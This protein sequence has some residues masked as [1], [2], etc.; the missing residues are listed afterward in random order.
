MPPARPVSE[1]AFFGETIRLAD[2]VSE[3]ALME[4]AEAA[5]Q[6]DD[7]SLAGMAAVMRL[8]KESVL[9]EDWGKFRDLART[10]KASIEDC[11]P[12]VVA[13]FTAE[14]GRPTV[15]PSDSSDGP[16]AT[17][18]S[19]TDVSAGVA[20]RALAGR[21]DLQLMVLNAQEARSA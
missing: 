14:T 12:V 11:M 8:L 6:V 3:W 17:S 18:T 7:A 2:S 10:N 21:P 1:V 5:E 4:F 16:P 13:V 9:A 15:R 20:V 19:S